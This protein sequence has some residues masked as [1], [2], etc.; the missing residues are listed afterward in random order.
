MLNLTKK[1]EPLLFWGNDNIECTKSYKYLGVDFRCNMNYGEICNSFLMKAKQAE[2][3]LFGLFYKANIT[4]LETR[5]QLFDSLTKSVLL[6]CSHIWGLGTLDKLITFQAK[7]LRK[8]FYLPNYTPLWFL[9]IKTNCYPIQLCVIK[10]A[11]NFVLKIL[12]RPESSAMRQTLNN[13]IKTSVC[14]KAKMKYNWYRDLTDFL[15]K[16]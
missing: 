16:Y 4:T 6:Y 5:L 2:N 12:R 11:M 13:L 9:R 3:Q 15:G 14:T 7:F 10:N 1:L 8:L